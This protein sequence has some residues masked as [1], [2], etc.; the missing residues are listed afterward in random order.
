MDELREISYEYESLYSIP[1]WEWDEE[2]DKALE[3]LAK[4]KL[5]IMYGGEET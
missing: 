3:R 2:M 4:R 1:S 5:E